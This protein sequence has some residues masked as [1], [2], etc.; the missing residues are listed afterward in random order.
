MLS[1]EPRIILNPKK[2]KKKRWC[3]PSKRPKYEN[4]NK[5]PH[6]TWCWDTKFFT[7][8]QS[9]FLTYSIIPQNISLCMSNQKK[10][11]AICNFDK[12][13]PKKAKIKAKI[14]RWAIAG[15]PNHLER[16]L[17]ALWI[18]LDLRNLGKQES[19]F[20]TFL[21]IFPHFLVLRHVKKF[22]STYFEC[23]WWIWQKLG[24]VWTHSGP[25]GPS[26]V[27]TI[28]RFCQ[29]PTRT[30]NVENNYSATCEW[31]HHSG[32]LNSKHW[33]FLKTFFKKK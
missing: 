19:Q 27:Q 13:V 12:K 9:W 3:R 14:S 7:K 24:M 22:I 11:R 28:P 1:L 30:Q 8:F 25:G 6:A 17:M 29:I 26:W 21:E 15:E 16:W 10:M 2:A 18:P 32:N 33:L 4:V 5:G 23:S 20:S 31:F